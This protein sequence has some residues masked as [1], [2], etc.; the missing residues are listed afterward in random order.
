MAT[1][2]VS[3]VSEV[4]KFNKLVD[5]L[6][7][8]EAVKEVENVSADDAINQLADTMRQN[9]AYNDLT[10]SIGFDA[11]VDAQRNPYNGKMEG[12]QQALMR[13]NNLV[14]DE[15][16]SLSGRPDDWADNWQDFGFSRDWIDGWMAGEIEG[17]IEV[18]ALIGKVAMQW[19]LPPTRINLELGHSEGFAPGK[20]K[21]DTPGDGDADS[22]TVTG[23]FS[24]I[25][26]VA[27]AARALDAVLEDMLEQAVHEH[28]INQYE[29]AR[30]RVDNI[31]KE[32]DA[33]VADLLS[34]G[35]PGAATPVETIRIMP[36]DQNATNTTDTP[37]EQ[38]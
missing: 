32:L 23:A 34:V 13:I 21:M 29:W 6:S 16:K 3:M 35:K 26:P 9:E 15:I 33:L 19:G 1:D 27:E 2:K 28:D 11:L 38:W 31:E 20:V 22:A 36:P 4:S 10:D 37:Q 24:A 30:G 5:T 14:R 7:K 12:A 25:G 17:R 8:S 18:R